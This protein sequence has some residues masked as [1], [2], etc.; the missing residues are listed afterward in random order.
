[1]M[2]TSPQ[3]QQEFEDNFKIKNDPRITKVGKFLPI[4]SLDDFPQLWSVLKG[5]M[6]VMGPRP[7]IADEVRKYGYY[8]K[9]NFNYQ[10]WNYWM[11]AGVGA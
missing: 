6:S 3:I 2:E 11:M 5:D 10:T 1:M 7:L 9:L 8:I 4:T